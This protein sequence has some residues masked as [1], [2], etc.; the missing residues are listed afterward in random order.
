VS[1]FGHKSHRRR[2]Y[3]RRGGDL[4]TR[5][6]LL[7]GLAG[8]SI[9]LVRFGWIDVAVADADTSWH[10]DESAQT[11]ASNNP[12]GHCRYGWWHDHHGDGSCC[13]KTPPARTPQPVPNPPTPPRGTP[14]PTPRRAPQPVTTTVPHSPGGTPPASALSPSPNVGPSD[15]TRPPVI[16]P[17]A[18]TVP[19]V[20]ALTVT[21]SHAR[22]LDVVAVSSVLIATT[23]AAVSLALIRRS[24]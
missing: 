7:M 22:A 2:P 24:D 19:P 6:A 10:A 21:G 8:A 15:Q 5:R 4:L 18:L 12:G 11:E 13:S 1:H 16:A 17:P 9:L 3:D 20:E 23:I 14:A